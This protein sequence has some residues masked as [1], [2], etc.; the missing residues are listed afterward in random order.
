MSTFL[1]GC[2]ID[3]QYPEQ[4]CETHRRWGCHDGLFNEEWEH[5]RG[6]DGME[7]TIRVWCPPCV[8]ARLLSKVS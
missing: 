6:A 5:V 7:Q 1:C 3:P 4:R 2:P 8:R